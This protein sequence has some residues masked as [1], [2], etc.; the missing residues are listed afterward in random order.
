MIRFKKGLAI[1]LST[2]MVFGM[3]PIQAGAEE[4]VSGN[5]VQTESASDT[6]TIATVQTLIDAL[7][8]ADS[9]TEDNVENVT[10]QLDT[11]DEAK[12]ELGDADMSQLDLTRYDAAINKVM[13]L[14]GMQEEAD[15][16]IAVQANDSAGKTKQQSTDEASV[17]INGETLYYATLEEAFSAADGKT[18][19]KIGRASCRERV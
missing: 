16:E 17:T 19:T 5:T 18:A 7:P 12:A 14:M 8:D 10:S 13:V 11:I 15:T 2:C 4:T 9:I 3:T 1:L 6:E